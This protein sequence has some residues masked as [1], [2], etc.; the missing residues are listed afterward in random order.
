MNRNP[1]ALLIL[2]LAMLLAPLGACIGQGH[3]QAAPKAAKMH[4][5]AGMHHN[6]E[7]TPGHDV[8][9]GAAK[10]HFCADCQPPTFVGAGKASFDTIS[11]VALAPAAAPAVVQVLAAWD[12]EPAHRWFGRAP[13]IPPPLPITTKV[14]LQI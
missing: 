12:A 2:T 3:A 6:G 4:H 8:H 13:P 5:A 9:K 11:F 14:R 10:H 7:A 1:V